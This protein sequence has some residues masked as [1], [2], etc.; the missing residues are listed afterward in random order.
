MI[1]KLVVDILTVEFCVDTCQDKIV[2]ISELKN[3]K[4][5]GTRTAKGNC[6]EYLPVVMLVK[7]AD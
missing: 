4:Q 1:L 2:D 7:Q 3:W 5:A 6:G